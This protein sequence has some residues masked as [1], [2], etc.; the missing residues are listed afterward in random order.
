MA[1]FLEYAEELIKECVHGR[2]LTRFNNGILIGSGKFEH[3][4]RDEE[5]AIHT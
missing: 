4:Q 5:E 3:L 2:D 1:S